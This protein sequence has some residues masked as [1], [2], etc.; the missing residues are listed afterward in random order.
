MTS[1]R[2]NLLRAGALTLGLVIGL[3][4]VAQGDTSVHGI[5]IKTADEVGL[6]QLQVCTS[7]QTRHWSNLGTNDTAV[8]FCP[9]VAPS[10]VR[11]V[12]FPEAQAAA[13][14]LEEKVFFAHDS[15]ELGE[16]ALTAVRTLST[17]LVENPTATLNLAGHTDATGTEEYNLDLSRRRVETVQSF[18]FANGGP[19]TRI[20]IKWFG[21]ARLVVDTPQREP[22]NRRVEFT[23][24]R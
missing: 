9:S 8:V 4:L 15:V 21:E 16:E 20:S 11:P 5:V 10:G 17:F 13:D 1:S 22:I 2:H 14:L 12:S 24:S 18:F 7:T 19:E 3:A 23:L 6:P